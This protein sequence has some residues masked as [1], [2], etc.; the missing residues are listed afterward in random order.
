MLRGLVGWAV[1]PCAWCP[2]TVLKAGHFQEGQHEGQR[3]RVPVGP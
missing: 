3:V 2:G 1:Y